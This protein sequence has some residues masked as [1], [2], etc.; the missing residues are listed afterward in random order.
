MNKI[1]DNEL[2]N[3]KE[4]ADTINIKMKTRPSYSTIYSGNGDT[5]L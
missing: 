1:E 4:T 5:Y 3:E 2:V